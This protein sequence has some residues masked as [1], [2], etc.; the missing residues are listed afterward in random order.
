MD[1]I[2]IVGLGPG[3]PR[4]LTREAWDVL[5][6]AN[7]VWLRTAHH[8]TVA[9]LPPHL[10]LHSFDHL[11][12]EAEGFAQVYDA[13][14]GEILRLGQRPE[15]VIY[16][17][18]GHPL[19]GEATVAQI[20]S[21][22]KEADLAVRIV[23]GLS[24]VE[25]TLTALRIDPLAGLQVYDAVE[26]A[27]CYHPPLNPDL[28]ALV[29]QLYSRTLAAD[30]KLTLM[31]Q[32]PDDHKVVLV[33]A[34]GTSEQRVVRLPLY[35]LDRR[36]DVAHLTTLYIP[37]LPGVTS[38]EGLQ[39]TVA[40]LRAPDGCPW[41][42]EQTHES[43][44]TGLLEEAY[45]A[46]AAIDAGDV[47]ALQEELGDLLLQVLL[48]TQIATEEGEFKM[49]QVIAGI[50][51]KL[52]HRHPHVWGGRRVS[53]TGE[54]LQR[55]EELK[56][57][58]KGEGRSVLDGVP[59][60]LP[61][62]QQADTYSR[63]AARV[64]FDW[65]GVGG[66]ADKVREEIAEVE[67]AATTEEREAELGDLLFAVVNWARWLGVDPEAALRKANARFAHRFRSMERM[68]RERG[69]DMTALTIDELEPLWREAKGDRGAE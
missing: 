54:V 38:F 34:A 42:R 33:H 39:D 27:A 5:E 58:E 49:A 59:A 15:G 40:H 28:P 60:I 19:V 25:P 14:A 48:Q 45:E 51:A 46:L 23:E 12:E 13:I 31:N 32:Y 62:L 55:W 53:G 37:S 43:L 57:E 69:L 8:P 29:G 52:K 36:D 44:R 7:E 26:L 64:G 65:T 24:F 16:A 2:T 63:R 56:R 22:A 41:D 35:E 68:A 1:S 67:A 10:T 6:A 50:D 66:V 30:V 20:L 17:V 18:P 61:A 9:G 21:R 3:D 47:Q 4:H 11:Y